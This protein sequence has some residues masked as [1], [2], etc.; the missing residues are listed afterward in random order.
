VPTTGS[1]AGE[2]AAL[3][4]R[5]RPVRD[6]RGKKVYSI[7]EAGEQRLHELLDAERPADDD[8]S[9]R[10]RLAFSR[11]LPAQGRVG[12]LERRRARLHERLEEARL[13]LRHAGD[14]LDPYTRSLMEHE[15]ESTEHDIAWLERLIASE[16]AGGTS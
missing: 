8:R 3:R 9:F 14:D 5:L 1:L 11:Y 4:N 13:A 12:L 7:T 16:Q 6:A 2:A 10:L 15:T